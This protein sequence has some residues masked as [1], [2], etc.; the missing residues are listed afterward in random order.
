MCE[1]AGEEGEQDI[2]FIHIPIQSGNS[3]EKKNGKKDD[4][5]MTRIAVE[6][7]DDWLN[8]VRDRFLFRYGNYPGH[9]L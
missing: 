1:K 4:L 6:P 3:I 8:E 2:G 5:I 9:V 7:G